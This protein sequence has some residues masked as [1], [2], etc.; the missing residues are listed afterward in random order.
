MPKTNAGRHRAY[1]MEYHGKHERDTRP[2][3]VERFA[4]FQ[5]S[6]CG[7][8]LLAHKVTQFRA[9]CARCRQWRTNGAINA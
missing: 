2:P 8:E 1:T 9:W 5:C 7:R 4:I 3:K 6:Q